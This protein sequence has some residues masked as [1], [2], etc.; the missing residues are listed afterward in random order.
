[1]PVRAAAERAARLRQQPRLRRLY[2]VAAAL[3]IYNVRFLLSLFV[4]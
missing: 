3:E 4:P 2:G 1:M